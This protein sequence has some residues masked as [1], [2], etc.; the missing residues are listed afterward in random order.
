MNYNICMYS[1]LLPKLEWL[2][3]SLL[4]W[5]NIS[6]TLFITKKKL[7]QIL[8]REIA[9]QITKFSNYIPT[10]VTNFLM[11]VNKSY[12]TS[13]TKHKICEHNKRELAPMLVPL[14]KL[15]VQTSRLSSHD[16]RRNQLDSN[17]LLSY[18]PKNSF[19][20]AVFFSLWLFHFL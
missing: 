18:F 5:N 7:Y 10:K 4:H 9:V 20:K 11:H 2:C 12:K 3:L 1:R 15:H 6:L 19:P 14:T 8:I 17:T 13:P 16:K